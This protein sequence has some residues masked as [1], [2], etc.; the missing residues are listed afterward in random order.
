MSK[1]SSHLRMRCNGRS[2]I[3]TNLDGQRVNKRWSLT[4]TKVRTTYSAPWRTRGLL[5]GKNPV[6]TLQCLLVNFT[7]FAESTRLGYEPFDYD[8]GWRTYSPPHSS[9]VYF[10][11]MSVETRE[12]LKP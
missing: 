7:E 11:A 1:R 4:S 2:W 9:L 5:Q 12:Q 3:C 6:A 8:E 10:R